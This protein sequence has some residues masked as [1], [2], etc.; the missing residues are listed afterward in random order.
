MQITLEK[1]T[2]DIGGPYPCLNVS[3]ESVDINDIEGIYQLQYSDSHKSL[4][5]KTAIFRQT[6]VSDF[7]TNSNKYRIKFKG[8]DDRNNFCYVLSGPLNDDLKA[9]YTIV[10]V[11]KDVV[12]YV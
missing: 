4:I 5:C 1:Y 8:N 11:D 9:L 6:K 2:N 7:S 10:N 12:E 3:V